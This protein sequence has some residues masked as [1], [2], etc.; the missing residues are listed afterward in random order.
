[1]SIFKELRTSLVSRLADSNPPFCSAPLTDAGHAIPNADARCMS[2]NPYFMQ[3]TLTSDLQIL[4]W[5]GITKIDRMLSMS[6]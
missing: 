6:K 3:P 4:H 1:M 2:G 5:L